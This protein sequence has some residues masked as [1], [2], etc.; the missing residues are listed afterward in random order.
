MEREGERGGFAGFDGAG[1]EVDCEEF[2]CRIFF[3]KKKGG[4][5]GGEKGNKKKRLGKNASLGGG[6]YLA[7]RDGR[8]F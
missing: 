8:G 3:Q 1:Q 7:G 4:G 2:H 6:V 5:G